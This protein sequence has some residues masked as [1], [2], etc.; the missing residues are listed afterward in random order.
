MIQNME[1]N[2]FQPQ[3]QARCQIAF[4]IGQLC[5]RLAC[6]TKLARILNLCQ[7]FDLLPSSDPPQRR[8]ESAEGV[9]REQRH[10][11]ERRNEERTSQMR[12]LM[13]NVMEA[14]A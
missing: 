13:L 1:G 10:A 14:R 5:I 3:L 2:F 4:S 11:F 9:D 8:H 12:P 7:D 6:R